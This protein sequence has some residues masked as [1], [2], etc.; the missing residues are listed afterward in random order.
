MLSQLSRSVGRARASTF[1]QLARAWLL[2]YNRVTSV[3][4]GAS[5]AAQLEVNVAAGEAP[6]LTAEEFAAIELH[7]IDGPGR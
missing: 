3:L 2:R 7:P 4:V 6:P 1:L 5:S